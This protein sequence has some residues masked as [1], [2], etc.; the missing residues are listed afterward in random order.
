MIVGKRLEMAINQSGLTRQSLSEQTGVSTFAILR[1]ESAS[2]STCP[3]EHLDKLAAAL[4][5]TEAW[6]A[7]LSDDRA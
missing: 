2:V 5:V 6:L 1:Y 4:G 3:R 7:G